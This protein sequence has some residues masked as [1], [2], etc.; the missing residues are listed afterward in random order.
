[1][2]EQLRIGI[3]QMNCLVG[4]LEGN[5]NRAIELAIQARDQHF[6]DAIVFPELA[7]TGYPPED[8]LLR[9]EFMEQTQAFVEKLA[10][11]ISGI[12]VFIGHPRQIDS[13]LYNAASV[14]SDNRII[15]TYHKHKLP[16]YAVFDEKRYFQNGLAPCVVELKGVKVGVTICE[17]IWDEFPIAQSVE[18]GAE[19]I[20]NLNASPFHLNKEVEREDAVGRRAAQNHVPIVYVNMVGGQDELV[21]DGNSFVVN[22][23]GKTTFRAP[24]FEEGLY[25]ADFTL[26][27]ATNVEPVSNKL[28]THDAAEPS[29]YKALV[30]GLR[31]YVNKNGFNGVV[32]GLSG[33]I[34]SALT[35]AIAV[36][37][38]G[39]ERVEA[40][41]MP[42]PYTAEMSL[43][44][45]RKEA[46]ALDVK[47]SEVPIQSI[48]DV[49]GAELS[50]EFQSYDDAR[51]GKPET[52]T[53]DQNIQARIRGL[54]LMAIANKKGYIALPTGN[55]SE[56]AVGYATLYGDMAGGFAVIK[57]VPKLLVYRLSEY[58]N[59]ISPVI[60]QRVIT[61]PPSAE[62]APDQIDEDNLPP[63]SVLDPILELY[64][65]H[66]MSAEEIERQ[67]GTDAAIVRRIIRLVISNEHKRRQAAPGVRIS[68]RAFGRDRRY[69]ITSGFRQKQ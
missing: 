46:E 37:A 19:L 61:R 12:T 14:I 5:C 11:E 54:L 66:D 40:V 30:T 51:G 27:G 23:A 21:F 39:S 38:I 44:D 17:D 4:N 43:A 35:L 59:T 60:P 6:C 55:K 31:D 33:G 50:D 53:T 34:D 8:L 29:V 32:I 67:L 28:C 69:P 36:D 41:M 1:M 26:S 49:I 68:H 9:P 10:A 7:L 65:E 57:D 62:L 13:R 20:V 16:N 48:V 56:M 18:A 47:Y 15:G 24:A 64:I 22:A 3:A 52:D 25:Y 45:A 63:Y 42:S 58:R 2:S